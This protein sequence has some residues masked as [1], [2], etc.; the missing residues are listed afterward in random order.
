MEA[1]GSVSELRKRIKT[2]G[3]VPDSLWNYT[4]IVDHEVSLV[5]GPVTDHLMSNSLGISRFGDCPQII[6][7]QYIVAKARLREIVPRES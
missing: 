5:Q 7:Q 6:N 4:C 1:F 3:E 2:D